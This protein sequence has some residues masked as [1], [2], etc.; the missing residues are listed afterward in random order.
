MTS[1]TGGICRSVVVYEL[2]VHF[3]LVR[4]PLSLGQLD[5]V[6]LEIH[7]GGLHGREEPGHLNDADVLE[8]DRGVLAFLAARSLW[9]DRPKR[10]NCWREC[11][12]GSPHGPP[13]CHRRTR[14]PHGSGR[15][16]FIRSGSI[17]RM[18]MICVWASISRSIVAFAVS[19]GR[20]KIDRPDQQRPHPDQHGDEQIVEYR[21]A[22]NSLACL[23]PRRLFLDLPGS[24]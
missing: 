16:S 9:A 15:P 18:P 2:E 7:P 4:H 11:C 1:A 12:T 10:C 20:R 13:P 14:P 24:R 19:L 21:I 5:P 6:A 17:S 8:L 3:P 23:C 22:V